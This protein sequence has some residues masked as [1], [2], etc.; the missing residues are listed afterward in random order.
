QMAVFA[1]MAEAMDESI[2]RV[3]DHLRSSGELDNTLIIFMSDNG[4]ESTVL[5]EVAPWFYRLRYDRELVALGSRG[6]WSEYGRGWGYA[7][8]WPCSS[9]RAS[10]DGGG[11]RV[12]LD[13]RHPALIVAGPRTP[14]FGYVMD[15]A[16][17]LLEPTGTP[18]PDGEYQGRPVHRS[19][20]TS[21]LPLLRGE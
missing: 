6:S 10:P 15:I 18:V 21:M 17:T 11:L 9:F 5:T 20:G 12:L 4:A 16:P 7:S 1:G 13:G 2:G 19:M 8:I 14:A 3:I